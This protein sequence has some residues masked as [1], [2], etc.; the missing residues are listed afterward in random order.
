MQ[1]PREPQRHEKKRK[2]VRIG[3]L[4]Y[5]GISSSTL[6]R[7][8]DALEDTYIQVTY[9]LKSIVTCS[10]LLLHRD[11]TRDKGTPPTEAAKTN[12]RRR[13]LSSRPPS[14]T[15]H[16]RG[17]TRRMSGKHDP[18]VATVTGGKF[19]VYNTQQELGIRLFPHRTN[20]PYAASQDSGSHR[21]TTLPRRA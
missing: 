16:S 12:R 15:V 5:R 19:A 20:S 11:R 3:S 9:D 8:L 14:F 10:S 18:T 7:P 2:K 17:F 13:F 1:I 6:A 4:D 21:C